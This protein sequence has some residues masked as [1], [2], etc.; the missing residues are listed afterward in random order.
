MAACFLQVVRKIG[1]VMR[2][3]PLGLGDL[4][5]WHISAVNAVQH[6]RTLAITFCFCL[7]RLWSSLS[8][9]TKSRN[10]ALAEQ[11]FDCPY[12]HNN[13]FSIMFPLL[14]QWREQQAELWLLQSTTEHPCLRKVYCPGSMLPQGPSLCAKL[15]PHVLP[16]REQHTASFATPAAKHCWANLR[17]NLYKYLKEVQQL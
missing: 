6:H 14:L 12:H 13:S 3:E 17:S 2:G 1:C 5:H 9:F 10:F 4:T 16:G 15:L 11:Y 8:A 7:K